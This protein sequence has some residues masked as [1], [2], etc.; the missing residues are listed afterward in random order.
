MNCCFKIA[1][2]EKLGKSSGLI[3]SYAFA[4]LGSN[5]F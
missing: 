1:S 3:C 2:T 5:F 4:D